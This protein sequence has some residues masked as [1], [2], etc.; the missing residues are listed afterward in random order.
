MHSLTKF[1]LL[2]CV[3]VG[4]MVSA[5]IA[6]DDYFSRDK[7]EAV[8]DR[9]QPEFDPEPIRLGAFKVVSRAEAG[10]SSDSNVF[11]SGT[12]EQSDVIA[13]I[14]VS[15]NARTDWSNN[16][17]QL[18]LGTFHNEYLDQDSLSNDD[19]RA[20]VRGRLDVSR[21]FSVAASVF[22][23]SRSEPLQNFANSVGLDGPAEFTNT[24]AQLEASYKTGRLRIDA[25]ARQTSVNF[26]DAKIIGGGIFDQDFRD[27]SLTNARARLTYAVTPN[28]ALFGQGSVYNTEYDQTQIVN[29]VPISRDNEGYRIQTGANFELTSLVRGDIAV[30]FFSNDNKN[31]LRPDIDGLSLDGRMIWF[32][33]QLTNITFRADR[34]VVDLGLVESPTGLA[35]GLGVRVDHELKRNIILSADVRAE[36]HDFDEIS[37][38]D[39]V[40]NIGLI[41][42]YKMNKRVAFEGFV[43]RLSRDVSGTSQNALLSTDANLIGIGIKLSP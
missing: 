16:E 8:M 31:P 18:T 7:Y 21:N 36:Q 2:A 9:R 10:L 26:K 23:E 13:R 24:G 28:F 19:L 11:A 20:K 4:P 17:V 6:Q 27:R 34:R 42:T 5:S 43:R 15:V 1:G 35:T 41:G 22:A 37:R 29:N 32:P 38:T 40:L 30:G 3:A 12:N 14:G 25:D 33:T 39:D